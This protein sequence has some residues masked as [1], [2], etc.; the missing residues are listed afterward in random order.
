MAGPPLLSQL[1]SSFRFPLESLSLFSSL[2]Y[3]LWTDKTVVTAK[4][5][6][7]FLF[8]QKRG[9]FKA[10]RRE[11]LVNIFEFSPPHKTTSAA[12]H[13]HHRKRGS[14][15]TRFE[16]RDPSDGGIAL[17]ILIRSLV[18]VQIWLIVF[19]CCCETP[20]SNS[21]SMNSLSLSKSVMDGWA[22]QG[23]R[24]VGCVAA[25]ATHEICH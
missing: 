4:A 24:V 9:L 22:N 21:S 5:E 25:A 12:L 14:F 15:D 1:D 13:T 8:F 6:P 23:W 7:P 3:A 11:R 20:N 18:Q 17:M 2:S 19:W 16:S 10:P